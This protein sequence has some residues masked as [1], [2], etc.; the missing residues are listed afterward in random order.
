MVVILSGE[1]DNSANRSGGPLG[2]VQKAL[3]AFKDG[4]DVIDVNTADMNDNITHTGDPTLVYKCEGGPGL[5][6]DKS[7][8]A[9][10]VRFLTFNA[11]MR[12]DD[13]TD[14]DRKPVAAAAGAAAGPAG[15]TKKTK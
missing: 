3:E 8:D 7:K 1:Y 10:D 12:W 6:T 15:S 2:D 4:A 11:M 5:S 13:K 9:G 14:P